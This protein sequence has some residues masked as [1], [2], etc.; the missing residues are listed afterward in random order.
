MQ[1]RD[2]AH[3]GEAE[4]AAFGGTGLLEPAIFA[5]GVSAKFQYRGYRTVT[6]GQSQAI[7]PQK[8][9]QGEC[10]RWPCAYKF[11]VNFTYGCNDWIVGTV[12]VLLDGKWVNKGNAVYHFSC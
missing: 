7:G 11:T 5:D 6:G 2:C 8:S 3:H 10:F 4:A 9:H 1:T 12:L